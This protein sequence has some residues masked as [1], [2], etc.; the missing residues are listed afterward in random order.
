R[1]TSPPAPR[2]RSRHE[3]SCEASRQATRPRGR[4]GVRAPR[5][6]RA[7]GVSE[8]AQIL[9]V[10]TH[11]LTQRIVDPTTL[12]ASIAIFT[13][14]LLLLVAG[15]DH[16]AFTPGKEV[17]EQSHQNQP[18]NRPSTP[19]IKQFYTRSSRMGMC[20]IT[21]IY[22]SNDLKCPRRTTKCAV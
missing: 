13:A 22:A 17:G 21:A 19:I 8:F 10:T 1:A 14:V 3:R 12:I 15:F 18:L 7:L 16:R 6:R 11:L 20:N 2:S 5:Y 4:D 9:L